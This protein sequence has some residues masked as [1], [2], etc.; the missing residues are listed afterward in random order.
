MR[1]QAV[2]AYGE[3]LAARH[4]IESGYHLI[5]RNWR[6]PGGE[7][8]IVAVDPAGTLAFVEVKTRQGLACGHPLESITPTKLARLRRLVGAW[9]AE[10]PHRGGI[11]ID[12]VAVTLQRQGAPVVEH[13]VGVQ[14]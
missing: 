1:T 6:G 8:D 14:S 5:A 10:H 13:V 4:L 12:V 2:G 9:L 11:R 7:L 3:R